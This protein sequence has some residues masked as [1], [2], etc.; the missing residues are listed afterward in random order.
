M[1]VE[2]KYLTIN[3]YSRPGVKIGTIK[4]IVVHW[5]ANPMSTAI[6]NRNYFE[7]LK[8]GKKNS[9]G[10]T[11]YASSHYIV[12]LEGEVLACVPEIEVAYHAS[13]A[14]KSHIGIGFAIRIGK[15]NLQVL[16]MKHY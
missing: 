5:V 11:I 2:N 4:G 15:D 9:S 7:G 1:R 16:P 8:T 13:S 12:G 10:S 3:P 14:N 6:A